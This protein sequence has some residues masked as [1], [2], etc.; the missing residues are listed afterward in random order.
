M[1]ILQQGVAALV[2]SAISGE[3]KI[4]PEALDL[5]AVQTLARKHKIENL[6]YY[7]AVNCGVDPKL[8]IMKELFV[9]TCKC[10]HMDQR[11]KR[12]LETLLAAFEANEIHHMPLKG[13]LLKHL[14]PRT[15]MRLMSD[16]DILIREEQY[17]R[18][19]QIV[20]DLGFTFDYETDHEIVWKNADLNLE[21][22]KKLVPER[23]REFYAYFGTGWDLA[24]PAQ[25]RPYRYEFSREDNMLFLFTHFTKHYIGSGI[26]VRHLVDLWVYDRSNPELNQS[27]ILGELKKMGLDQFYQNVMQTTRVWFEGEAAT[28]VSDFI[29]DFIFESGVY[30]RHTTAVLAFAAR[31]SRYHGGR[32]RSS[33]EKILRSVF[34]GRAELQPEYPVLKKAPVLLPFVW[35]VRGFRILLFDRRKIRRKLRDIEEVTDENVKA[36]EQ[37]LAFVGLDFQPKESL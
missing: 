29:T 16:A 21:L 1:D 36:Y 7:G 31:D 35:I 32:N 14:Y 28:Q 34:P 9:T 11:Q 19:R 18:I 8:P 27:Y 23:S 30:G 33:G 24:V 15:D 12:Q 2:H 13:V 4:L 5:P 20:T 3:A 22:H 6:V 10:V 25:D 37:A 26:G 17:P